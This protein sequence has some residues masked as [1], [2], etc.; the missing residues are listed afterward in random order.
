[1]FNRVSNDDRGVSF[2]LIGT[3]AF[4]ATIAP[5][6]SEASSPGTSVLFFQTIG[7]MVAMLLCHRFC[8]LPQTR[9]V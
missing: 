1:M 5:L 7:W 2:V 9:K 3:V 6:V 8:H 4:N